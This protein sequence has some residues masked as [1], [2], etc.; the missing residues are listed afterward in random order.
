MLNDLSP[1]QLELENYMSE[2]SGQAYSAGWMDGLEFALW[3]LVIDGPYKYGQLHLNSEHRQSL[4]ELS[5]ACHG[6]I[7]FHDQFDETF[8]PMS[9]W[10][11][12]FKAAAF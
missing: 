8:V 6:W 4:V 12:N 10:L 9:Q 1:Q 3:K 5:G 7:V 11:V 2:L